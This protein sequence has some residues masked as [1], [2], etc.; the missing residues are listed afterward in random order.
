[1]RAFLLGCVFLTLWAGGAQAQPFSA[2]L[3]DF[4]REA[5]E[6]GIEPQLL[7]R[8]FI[9][10]EPQEDVLALDRKQP[11][12]TI[13]FPEY[14]RRILS[15]KKIADGRAAMREYASLL[16]Q[17]SKR[18]G[19]EPEYIVALWGMESN[20][21]EKSGDFDLIESLVTLAYDGRRSSYFRGEL[22][23]ALKILQQDGINPADFTGSWA[24]AMGQCQFM[25]TSFLR[26]AVDFDGD[27]KRDIWHSQADVFASTANYLAT[28]GWSEGLGWGFPVRLPPQRRDLPYAWRSDKITRTMTEW[29]RSGFL[30]KD[31]GEL[32]ESNKPMRLIIPEGEEQ[33]A[34][35]VTSNYNTILDWNR[36]IYFA[37]AVGMLAD[38]IGN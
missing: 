25:P 33:V 38:A 23:N 6:Q 5:Q 19:V 15:E 21:G 3:E 35:L 30:K 28:V 31:G 36:S 26:Y 2:W 29:A 4:K 34:Y 14:A 7:E 22:L 16:N 1:M 17:V 13:T 10:I 32:P 37:T 9:D 8:V 27:G 20:Y 24:G 18:Y 11:E 12:S